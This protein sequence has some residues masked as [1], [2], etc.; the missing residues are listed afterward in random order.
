MFIGASTLAT[1][2]P[3]ALMLPAIS[4]YRSC[5]GCGF[6]GRRFIGRWL[7]RLRLPGSNPLRSEKL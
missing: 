4:D 5:W 6:G 7:G 2:L 3:A 1:A